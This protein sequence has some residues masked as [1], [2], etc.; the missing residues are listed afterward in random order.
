MKSIGEIIFVVC[1]NDDFF[2]GEGHYHL[3]H[4]IYGDAMVSHPNREQARE[5]L[6]SLPGISI[7]MLI[8]PCE[9]C[10]KKGIAGPTRWRP[11]TR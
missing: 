1:N 11:I 2:H 9:S 5:V 6:D 7:L 3:Q 10:R 4:I 8:T